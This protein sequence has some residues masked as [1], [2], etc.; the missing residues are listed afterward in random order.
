MGS[1]I[2]KVEIPQ[3]HVRLRVGEGLRTFCACTVGK[4]CVIR[5]EYF[6]M[7]SVFYAGGA[8]STVMHGAETWVTRLQK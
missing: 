5:S 1:C 4:F 6:E 2:G 7:K 8:L 3:V